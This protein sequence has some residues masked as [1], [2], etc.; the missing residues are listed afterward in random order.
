MN[1]RKTDN[2]NFEYKVY[3]REVNLPKKKKIR[4]LDCFHGTGKIWNKIKNRHNDIIITGIEKQ[5]KK[6][7]NNEMVL[8]GDCIKYI[9]NMNLSDYDIIDLDCYGS[10]SKYIKELFL[11][12]TI[13]K[14]TIIF[15]T[16]IYTIYGR[17]TI[18]VLKENNISNEMY[19]KCPSVF[20]KKRIDFY[21]K[22]LYNLNIK[23][24]KEIN[25]KNHKYYGMFK[26]NP[27]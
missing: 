9:K 13:K 21:Y 6:S 25:I 23:K 7:N 18:E 20:N 8:Y 24:I 12:K 1:N 4:V 10:P 19:K 17:Q 22:F 14:N 2:T 3:L 27:E 11:N 26:I 5:Y 16:N 15:Y